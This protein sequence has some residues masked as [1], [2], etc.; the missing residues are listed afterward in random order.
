MNSGNCLRDSFLLNLRC[1][2]IDAPWTWKV[3][4]A[5]STPIIIHSNHC[6]LHLVV[7]FYVVALRPY[8]HI[9]MP[10]EEGDNHP[11][12]YAA[13]RYRGL[14]LLR[15][16]QSN[17]TG[18]NLWIYE[19]NFQVLR[20]SKVILHMKY[21]VFIRIE[22]YEISIIAQRSIYSELLLRKVNPEFSFPSNEFMMRHD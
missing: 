2:D 15:R 14:V 11:I 3:L 20:L 21:D 16:S 6:I 12:F 22:L 7:L 5:K 10:S 4:F 19:H 18:R 17:R 13:R 9:V 8:W 1:P